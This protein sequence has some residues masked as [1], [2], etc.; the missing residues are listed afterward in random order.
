[1]EKQTDE[2]IRRELTEF[3]FTSWLMYPKVFSDYASAQTEYGPVRPAN[4]SLFL[5]Y[6]VEDEILVDIER[7]K[8][9]VIRCLSIGDV[10]EKGMA[11][12][13][14]SCPRWRL[15]LDDRSIPEMCRYRSRS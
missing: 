4:A 3:E 1:L 12:M 15:R 14:A 6:E 5:W 11:P 10:D 7:S 13:P 9:P 2:N 8:M